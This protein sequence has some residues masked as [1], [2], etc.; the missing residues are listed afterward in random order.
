MCQENE[1]AFVYA[2]E[3]GH[4]GKDI[5]NEES[6]LYYQGAIISVGD[7]SS[8]VAPIIQRYCTENGL[9]RLHG[10]ELGEESK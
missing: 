8:K 4:S 5:F 9:E 3:S 2:G 7:I 6:P 10:Y 1:G